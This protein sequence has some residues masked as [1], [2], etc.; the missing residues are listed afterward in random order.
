MKRVFL[1]AILLLCSCVKNVD[2][3]QQR[4]VLTEG[5]SSELETHCAEL[6]LHGE[7]SSLLQEIHEK[8]DYLIDQLEQVKS[9]SEVNELY[10]LSEEIRA[11]IKKVTEMLD[12]KYGVSK[13]KY[14]LLWNIEKQ[15]FEDLLGIKFKK[16]FKLLN[17]DFDFISKSMKYL[18]I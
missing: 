7:Y 11:L 10:L 14:E 15:D 1:L 2:K 5:E 12:P 8:T 9:D 13:F 6:N 18:T 3:V 17:I 16:G 4:F